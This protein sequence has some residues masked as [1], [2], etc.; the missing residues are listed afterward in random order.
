LPTK[1]F[2]EAGVHVH[3]VGQMHVRKEGPR[4]TYFSP[5]KLLWISWIAT[6][7]LA[8]SLLRSE[9][10]IVQLCKPQ[11]INA[12]AARIGAIGRPIFCDC[13]DY[14]AETNL[15][16]RPW[17]KK[18]V[19]IFEDGIVNYASGITVNTRFSLERYLSLGFPEQ[20]VIYIPNGVERA[21]FDKTAQPHILRQ[22]WGLDQ[23]TPI[24]LYIGTLGIQSHPIDLLITAFKQINQIIPVSRLFIIG[25]G[26]DYDLLKNQAVQLGLMDS[27]IFT[28][29]VSPEEVPDYF[30]MAS[31]TV[32]PIR[33]DLI[34]KARSPLK[35]LESF[36]SGT[37]VITS[38]VGDRRDLLNNGERGVLIPAG[39]SQAL[40]DGILEVLKN[41]AYRSSLSK[42]AYN[43]RENW[44]WDNLVEDFLQVYSRAGFEV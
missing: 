4:K 1:I 24:V 19:Q 28:G 3:Y 39:S 36:A 5:G 22:R 20:R 15:F 8:R 32:D 26:E 41:P 17:Q 44:Y 25:G 40:A 27:V 43:S 30:A 14:E 7:K 10:E 9:A 12:L 11:P 42:A 35:V 16:T 34:A 29:R 23:S 37:P 31:V 2:T 33:D 13:D 6:L 18:I 21:R 38:D